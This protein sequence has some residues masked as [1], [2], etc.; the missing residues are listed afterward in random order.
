MKPDAFNCQTCQHKNC[1][2][3]GSRAGSNGPGLPGQWEIK[4]VV[5]SNVCLLPMVSDFSRECLR[6]YRHYKNGILL[7]VGGV[8]DQP[9]LYMQAMGVIDARQS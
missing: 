2:S 8:Y 5:K 7:R 6:L 9:N 1:D 3:D 4:G